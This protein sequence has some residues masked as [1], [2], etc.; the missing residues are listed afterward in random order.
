M[1][2]TALLRYGQQEMKC[3]I[4]TISDQTMSVI[5]RRPSEY[6]TVLQKIVV[7]LS[8]AEAGNTSVNSLDSYVHGI[9]AV[10]K[11]I[12]ADFLSFDIYFI[13]EDSSKIQQLSKFLDEVGQFGH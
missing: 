5:S 7:D 9:S 6:P 10:E 3:M 2:G 4:K 1:K 13:D 8:P 12:D 11:S